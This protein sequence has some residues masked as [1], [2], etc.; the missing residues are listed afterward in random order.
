VS[1]GAGDAL[2]LQVAAGIAT[3][4]GFGAATVNLGAG[5]VCLMSSGV[6]SAGRPEFIYGGVGSATVDD[7]A[8]SAGTSLTFGRGAD[9]VIG[10]SGANVYSLLSANLAGVADIIKDLKGAGGLRA[11]T[12]TSRDPFSMP[13]ADSLDISSALRARTTVASS[14]IGTLVSVAGGQSIL[15][16]GTQGFVAADIHWV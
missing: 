11:P 12:A 4:A 7:T 2:T 15:L 1:G 14:S 13:G 16:A 3:V 10:G 6:G 5:S 8:V 9:T